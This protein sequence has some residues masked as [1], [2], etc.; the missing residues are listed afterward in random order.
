MVEFHL[1][2][3]NLWYLWHTH[4]LKQKRKSSVSRRPFQAFTV[5]SKRL[6][7][8]ASRP[9]GS[10]K[11]CQASFGK[12]RICWGDS[13]HSAWLVVVNH[14]WQSE[15]SDGSKGDDW[16]LFS[17][18]LFLSLSL[19]IYLPTHLSMYPS[20]YLSISLSVCLSTYLSIY[21]SFFFSMYLSTYLSIY[22]PIYLSIL[23]YPIYLSM[24]LSTYLPIYLPTYLC[25]YLS[26][27][28]S[29]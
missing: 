25:I 16:C 19:T 20:I 3:Q 21:L 29:I 23:S 26:I 18:S 13:N 11:R 15:G 28:P 22:L 1:T 17:F 4:Q 24:Y 10:A 6:C 2:F 5:Q 9:T 7:S 14:G 8:S 12:S 27:Y